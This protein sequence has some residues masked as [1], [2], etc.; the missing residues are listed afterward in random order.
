M[1]QPFASSAW[2][3]AERHPFGAHQPRGSSHQGASG[4]T[5]IEVLVAIS[6]IGVLVSLLTPAVQQAREAAR[7]TECT[8][9]LK[10]IG[11]AFQNHHTQFRFFPSGGWNWNTPPSYVGGRP[12]IGADQRAGWGFQILPFIEG[13]DAWQA[14][15]EVVIGETREVYFC[16]SRR[17]PQTVV[18]TDSYDPPV[19]GDSVLR[20]L[21]DYAASNRDGSGVVRRFVPHKFRDIV[22]GT[23]NTFLVGEKRLNLTLLGT[24]ADDDNEGY[25]AGWN[26]DTMR[27]TEK[28][29]LPDLTGL[30]DGDDRFGSSHPGLFLAVLAD[31]STRSIAY[32]ID[33]VVFRHLGDIDDGQT[34]PEY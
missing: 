32:E 30:G 33:T 34:I 14:G 5:L 23:A 20:A 16:P 25:T 17:S 11:L 18:D 10:Q 15:A 29:P 24:G 7:R 28:P 4:F 2:H 1:K 27:S 3:V 6:I 8:N 13:H 19:T 9:H 26:S 12:Q 31:G 21:C 22:D